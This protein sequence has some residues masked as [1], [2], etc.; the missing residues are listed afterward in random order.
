MDLPNTIAFVITARCNLRCKMCFQY[1]ER[2]QRLGIKGNALLGK[3]KEL[4]KEEIKMVIDK[5]N[6]Y[7]P[8]DKKPNFFI[9]GGEPFIR[10]DMIDIIEYAVSQGNKVIVNTNFSLVNDKVVKKL[11]NIERLTLLISIDGPRKIHDAIRGVKGTYIKAMK[12]LRFLSKKGKMSEVCTTITKYNVNHLLELYRELVGL[13]IYWFLKHVAWMPEN[14]IRLQRKLSKKYFNI[15]FVVYLPEKVTVPPEKIKVLK[16][17]LKQIQK[18][19]KDDSVEYKEIARL[20][21]KSFFDQ[22]CRFSC[23]AMN[24][25]CCGPEVN[26]LPNGDVSF[27]NGAGYG[28]GPIYANILND[29]LPQ[30]LKKKEP[31]KKVYNQLLKKGIIFPVCVKCSYLENEN[32]VRF[33]ERVKRKLKIILKDYVG[34]FYHH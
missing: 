23:K 27:C 20:P 22:H 8:P 29:D 16:T 5:V 17:Q 30:I 28:L 26:I 32:N 2:A 9:T 13:K 12:N 4:T 1:G 6:K 24:K 14:F 31:L 10:E 18:L 34:N 3:P 7:Y 15:D 19:S 33:L 11:A 25:I 21:D